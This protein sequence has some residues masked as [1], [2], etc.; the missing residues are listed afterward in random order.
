MKLKNYFLCLCFL[1]TALFVKAQQ[2]TFEKVFMP[3]EA[4]EASSEQAQILDKYLTNY[5]LLKANTKM[6]AGIAHKKQAKVQIELPYEGGMKLALTENQVLSAHFIAG[7][8][9]EK[10]KLPY[11]YQAG[12]YYKGNITGK[13]S[14]TAMSFFENSIS[15]ILADEKGNIVLGK[16]NHAVS[17]GLYLIYRESDLKQKPDFQCATAEIPVAPS[18]NPNNAGL[19]T[20][21]TGSTLVGCPIDMY[22]ECDFALYGFNSNNMTN[23][24]NYVTSLFN[25]VSTLYN[26]ENIALQVAQVYV[27]TTSDPFVSY[28]ATNTM[29]NAFSAHMDTTTYTGDLAHL[30]SARSVGGGIAWLDVLCS[31]NYYK[32]GLSCNLNGFGTV[33]AYSWEANEVTHEIGHNLG[34][35]HTQWCGWPGG[36]IDNCYATEGGCPFGPAPIN[37]GTMMSYCH[38]TSYGVNFA[39]GFGPLPGNAVR[40]GVA[41]AMCACTNTCGLT[42]SVNGID[43]NCGLADGS[44]TAN[45]IGGTPPFSYLWN[46]GDT[47][48][49]LLNRPMGSYTLIVTD[50]NGCIIGENINLNVNSGTTTLTDC[51][52]TITDGSASNE[53]VN[54][55]NC[56]WLIQPA[57]ASSITLTFSNFD[58][59]LDYD[60]VTVYNGINATAPL[61]GQYSG[62]TL[63]PVLTANSGKIFI[64]FSSDI[65]VT[66]QGWTASY[67]SHTN[68]S[69]NVSVCAGQSYTYNGNTYSTSGSYTNAISSISGCDSTVI[70]N[71][72]VL[73][74]I[75]TNISQTNVSCNGGNNGT[76]SVTPTGGA[77]GYA[78]SWS[79]G[80]STANISGLSAGNYTVFITDNAGCTQTGNVTITQASP[81]SITTNSSA[82]ACSGGND[83]SISAS[84]T[85]GTGNYAYSW[86]S[87]Q[88]TATITNLQ[89]GTYIVFVTDQNN[90]QNAQTSN[91]SNPSP[92]ATPITQSNVTCFN[93]NNGSATVSASGGTGNFFYS[94]SNGLT[95]A[96]ASFLTAGAY[97]VFVTDGNN[98]TTAQNVNITQPAAINA[99]FSTNPISCNGGNNGS[100]TVIPS[101]G[102]GTFSYSWNNGQTSATAIGLVAGN[103]SVLLTD[104]N[105]CTQIQSVNLAQPNPIAATLTQSNVSCNGGNNGT[106]S[107][108]ASGGTGNYSYSWSNTQTTATASGL[109]AGTYSVT[110]SD[111]NN[112]TQ[113]QSVTITQAT[114]IVISPSQTNVSCNGG[115]NG[116]ASG[117]ATG[118]TGSYSYAWNNGQIGANAINLAA[119]TYILTVKD[120]NNCTQTQSITITAPSAIVAT[121]NHTD[122]TC[123]NGNDGSASAAA[124]GGTGNLSYSWS[125]GQLGASAS[126]LSAGTYSLFV[127]DQSNCT[128]TAS[129]IINNA[130]AIT[131]T[132]NIELCDGDSLVVG[133]SVYYTAGT[134]VD[135]LTSVK[136]CDSTVTSIVTICTAIENPFIGQIQVYPIPTNG[137]DL[138]IEMLDI[139]AGEWQFDL[140]NAIGQ[141]LLQES[142]KIN[143]S[144]YKQQF[145]ISPLAYGV[146]FLRISNTAGNMHTWRIERR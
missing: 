142:R 89:A 126:N 141:T 111:Q 21:S 15:G 60:F 132:Q 90:C 139:E 86:S 85:G 112:C 55:I 94:W 28:T 61:L 99:T 105:N 6:L 79:N 134:F 31:N 81:I 33:P 107:V 11:P 5:T 118:G 140:F 23:T 88:T 8:I 51:A 53:Y 73:S 104:A 129:V 116:T 76:A 72:T 136:G 59:E 30:L 121:T 46:T 22:V 74:P 146:Y 29:L 106:A 63:P 35:N 97:T 7:S 120:A 110:I 93:G 40:N 83:G 102:T 12:A 71:L 109:T 62:N 101:G 108:L 143:S 133:T 37:G 75:N 124:S 135:I 127:T 34:S 122:V 80:Q 66:A 70:T 3:F 78:Y 25:N 128:Q 131:T 96:M 95:G 103:Y 2:A 67:T 98:C 54:N 17:E 84:A 123:F 42:L 14:I 113:I 64:E 69:Q 19:I 57:G 10:G 20:P 16:W 82:I 115:N 92:I 24:L 27:Y 138:F 119:G 87:G 47:M 145:D 68:V 1:F 41:N 44:L 130:Q 144:Y 45:P 36:A 18:P 52:G 38:L 50:S 91:L 56:S 39:N 9:S 49:A 125:N 43:A 100:I 114:A 137:N 65:F 77:G 32:C 48:A 26:N 13:K 117:I 4:V 58:T